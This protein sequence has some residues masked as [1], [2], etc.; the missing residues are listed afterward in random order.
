MAAFIKR[1]LKQE[2]ER[3]R[4]RAVRERLVELRA[5]IKAARLARREAL[6]VIRDQCKAERKAVTISCDLRRQQA[7]EEARKAVEERRR[8][9]GGVHSE[10]R[11]YREADN[12]ER[13]ASVRSTARE[14]RSEDDDSVRANLPIDLVPVF[15]KVRRVIKGGPRKSRTEAFLQ[16]AEENPEEVLSMQSLAADRDVDRLV[17]EYE[18]LQREEQRRGRRRAAVPF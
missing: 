13:K 14:R 6:I 18:Q 16:W 5:Q 12:R 1:R 7:R 17:A 8:Q 15:D 11:I 10:E 9:I 3:E 2:I 4:K